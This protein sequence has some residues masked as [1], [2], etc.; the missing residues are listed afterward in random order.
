M[1][2]Y[3]CDRC[4]N[5]I[6]DGTIYYI[7]SK[8]IYRWRFAFSRNKKERCTEIEHEIC[9]PCQESL[10]HW[11]AEGQTKP[12]PKESNLTGDVYAVDAHITKEE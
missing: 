10:W 1:R 3:F 5:E 8:E 4:G 6:E 7:R 12:S 2:K 11:W 9:T